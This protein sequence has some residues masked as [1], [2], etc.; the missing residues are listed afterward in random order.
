MYELIDTQ[1]GLERACRELGGPS[2]FLDTEFES[3][4][5]GAE[6]CLLQLSNGERIFLIDTL[7]LH[8]LDPLFAL[9]KNAREWVL[10]SGL[11]DVGL[12]RSRLG[13]KDPPPIFDTQ[14]CWA[15][16][17]AEHSV[18]LAYLVYRVLGVRTAK[19]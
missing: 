5:S 11:Q 4:R 3:T 19:P 13:L 15:L 2:V 17:S 8:A 18:S 1:A 16:I 9:L 14:V 7:R 10:H 12:L 6:L